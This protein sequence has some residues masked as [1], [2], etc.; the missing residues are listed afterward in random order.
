MFDTTKAV[1][2]NKPRLENKELATEYDAALDD[3][4]FNSKSII[5]NLTVIA[6]ENMSS[7]SDI[8][9]LI[10]NRIANVPLFLL[11]P[12]ICLRILLKRSYQ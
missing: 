8:V 12:L 7:A 5:D 9:T 11:S 4:T 3:L 6:Q 1:Q 2:M 10:E